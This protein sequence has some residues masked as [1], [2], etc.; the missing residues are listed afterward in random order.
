MKR[1][2]IDGSIVDGEQ[3]VSIYCFHE[4]VN[5][6]DHLMTK[7]TNQENDMRDLTGELETAVLTMAELKAK[8]VMY[9]SKVLDDEYRPVPRRDV[10][11]CTE[12]DKYFCVHTNEE[13]MKGR[14]DDE[15]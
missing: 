13:V 9:E 8:L 7:I 2:E 15:T 10:G 12:C 6:A 14:E 4:W 5:Y 1:P 11:K 3:V